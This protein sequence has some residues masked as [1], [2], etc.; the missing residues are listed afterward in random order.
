MNHS[1]KVYKNIPNKCKHCKI[2]VDAVLACT[3][4]FMPKGKRMEIEIYKE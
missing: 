1:R 4:S 3:L 2:Q